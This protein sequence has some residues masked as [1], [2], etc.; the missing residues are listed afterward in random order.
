M[1]RYSSSLT[2]TRSNILILKSMYNFQTSDRS[3]KRKAPSLDFEIDQKYCV[4]LELN[5]DLIKY[6]LKSEAAPKIGCVDQNS[7]IPL[8]SLL[9]W[10]KLKSFIMVCNILYLYL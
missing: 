7:C 1:N 3:L 4:I 8:K 9:I 6:R 2:L 5:M 10:S